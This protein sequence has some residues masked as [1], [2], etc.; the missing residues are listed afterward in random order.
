MTANVVFVIGE[1]SDGKPSSWA[2]AAIVW[3]VV[4]LTVY[5]CKIVA[6]AVRLGEQ[7]VRKYRIEQG[8]AQMNEW[9]KEVGDN[10]DHGYKDGTAYSKDA[11][12]KFL[13]E[14][15]VSYFKKVIQKNPDP[16]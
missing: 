8:R 10:L 7:R 14:V 11:V 12:K 6:N 15:S 5:V 9:L 1:I 2:A 4:V 13:A 3:G 16:E